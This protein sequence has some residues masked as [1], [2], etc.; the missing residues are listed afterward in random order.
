MKTSF[1][2]HGLPA[3]P[4]RGFTMIEVLIALLVLAFGLLG[5]ALLQTMN[6]RFTQSANY[7]TQATNLAYDLLDQIRANRLVAPQYTAITT[8][9][10]TGLK[11][12][13][14]GARPMGAVTVDDNIKRW[15][16]QVV[17]TLGEGSSAVVL[18]AADGTVNVTITW[19][20]V[21]WAAAGDPKN[22]SF[23]V[24]TQL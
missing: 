10:F 4:P 8:A 20:D 12:K 9:S 17:D 5:F 16:C 24:E 3:R 21:R 13:S 11:A 1:R 2:C 23:A 7:R 15:R 19:G 6:L 18:Y 14:C 22:R